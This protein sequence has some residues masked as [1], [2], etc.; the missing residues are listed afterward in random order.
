MPITDHALRQWS[1]RYAESLEGLK[2]LRVPLR[3]SNSNHS[4][5]PRFLSHM[6]R[7]SCR[8]SFISFPKIRLDLCIKISTDFCS[9][10]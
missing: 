9:D 6:P 4:F 7:L 5:I 3:L 8:S 10:A 1:A 2:D